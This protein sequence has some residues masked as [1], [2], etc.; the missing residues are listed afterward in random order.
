M[1]AE[2]TPQFTSYD[3]EFQK[4]VSSVFKRLE[5]A[6]QRVLDL[7]TVRF[8]NHPEHF[9]VLR[10]SK[11]PER[12][13]GGPRVR[14]SA[15]TKRLQVKFTAHTNEQ[16]PEDWRLA[17]LLDNLGVREPQSLDVSLYM[18]RTRKGLPMY[19]SPVD[20]RFELKISPQVLTNDV[21]GV[22]FNEP[23][24][25]DFFPHP[26]RLEVIAPDNEWWTGKARDASYWLALL[27]KGIVSSI[28]DPYNELGGHVNTLPHPLYVDLLESTADWLEHLVRSRTE[29]GS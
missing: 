26:K 14:F 25:D 21:L 28:S 11:A 8:E 20:P 29:T 1:A 6:R 24:A 19:K 23:E 4:G 17:V 7:E 2:S 18:I 3:A 15:P 16:R 22:T 27:G 13:L 10:G 9:N 12:S 5:T